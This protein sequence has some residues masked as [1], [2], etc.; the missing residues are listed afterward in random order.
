MEKKFSLTSSFTSAMDSFLVRAHLWNEISG[1]YAAASF[2]RQRIDYIFDIHD[3]HSGIMLKNGKSIS[4]LMGFKELER[5]IYFRTAADNDV[6]DL[7]DVTGMAYRFATSIEFVAMIRKD[8]SREKR[9]FSFNENDVILKDAQGYT[10]EYSSAKKGMAMSI[11]LCAG[12]TG[13]FGEETK[14]IID[15]DIVEFTE[16]YKKAK[17]QGCTLNLLPFANGSPPQP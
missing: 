17:A 2:E 13:P 15:M 16:R 1:E 14:I 4:V 12:R 5:N 9:Q 10:S 11:P 3:R 6:L 8:S 7:L